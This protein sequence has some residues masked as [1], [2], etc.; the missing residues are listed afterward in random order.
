MQKL[1]ADFVINQGISDNP[2][3][4]YPDRYFTTKLTKDKNVL[5]KFGM[6]LRYDKFGG[7]FTDADKVVYATVMVSISREAYKD[8]RNRR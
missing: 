4:S 7:V 5:W 3:I 8:L 1:Y 2:E 6:K